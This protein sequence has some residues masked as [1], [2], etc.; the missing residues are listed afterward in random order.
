MI[1]KECCGKDY[2]PEDEFCSECGAELTEKNV[3]IACGAELSENAE[4]CEIC[5]AVQTAADPAVETV[6][7]TVA[8]EPVYDEDGNEVYVPMVE[9]EEGEEGFVY[10]EPAP[11]VKPKKSYAKV[12]LAIWASVATVGAAVL[13]TLF[14]LLPMLTGSI[15]GKWYSAVP[16]ADGST[17]TSTYFQFN[18]GGSFE[19]SSQGTTN[20][21]Q[22][23]LKGSSLSLTFDEDKTNVIKTT[24]HIKDNVMYI[25]L[26]NGNTIRYQKAIKKAST[27]SK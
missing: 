3:C 27:T 13:L 8:S 1:K 7:E 23:K 4:S 10:Q 9:P 26:D 11:E 21:G 14:I 2:L 6:T 19:L 17:D 24:Y 5:G 12:I 20:K 16:Q 25:N 15:V 22:Y 18:K